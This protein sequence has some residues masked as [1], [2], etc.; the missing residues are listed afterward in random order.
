MKTFEE[1]LDP[2]QKENEQLFHEFKRLVETH[3]QSFSNAPELL[4]KLKEL[5]NKLENHDVDIHDIFEALRQL[6]GLPAAK[7]TIKGFAQK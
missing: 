4:E 5:E 2:K 6:M 1:L 7:K 3:L